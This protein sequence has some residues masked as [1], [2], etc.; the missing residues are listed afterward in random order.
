ME[1]DYGFSVVDDDVVGSKH[2]EKLVRDYELR[3]KK[4]E[5]IILPFLNKLM[6]NSDKPLINWPKRK[7][8]IEQQIARIIAQT[9][10]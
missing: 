7:P 3:L 1:N 9:R 5:E 6:E 8:I 2:H 10:P 4:V